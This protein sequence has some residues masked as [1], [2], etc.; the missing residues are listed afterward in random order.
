MARKEVTSDQDYSGRSKIIRPLLSANVLQNEGELGW[1]ATAHR[2]KVRTNLGEKKVLLEGD[3]ESGNALTYSNIL[4]VS[5]AGSDSTAAKGRLDKP[6]KTL[7]A[8]KNAAT[9]GDLIYVFPGR[10]DEYNLL[11]NLVNWYFMDGAVVEPTAST[12]SIFT[13]ANGA[14]TSSILGK[15][16]FVSFGLLGDD[17]CT[18]AV[19]NNGT[20]LYI[21]ARLVSGFHTWACTCH[22]HFR[23]VEFTWQTAPQSGATVLFENCF[24]NNSS[25]AAPTSHSHVLSVTYMNCRF[26]RLS[27]LKAGF[28]DDFTGLN[29]CL[30]IGNSDSSTNVQAAEFHVQVLNCLFDSDT[31]SC[32]ATFN[33]KTPI[34]NSCTIANSFFYNRSAAGKIIL[35]RHFNVT[36]DWIKYNLIGNVS[37]VGVADNCDITNNLPDAGIFVNPQFRIII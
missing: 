8:A 12:Q 31:E 24:F 18:V 9:S 32:I 2:P 36:T 17:A 13:D 16:R 19:L 34:K 6:F 22:V 33:Y 27:S 26:K 10:Y 21:E 29:S 5:P 15:G 37:N 7:T 23:G 14:C 1:D 3:V 20:N 11:K 25:N 35:P 30:Q 4:Y 28:N